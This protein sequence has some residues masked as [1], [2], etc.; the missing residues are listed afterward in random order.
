MARVWGR[1][2]LPRS[3]A[4]SPAIA[5]SPDSWP[6]I[7]AVA[8]L[9]WLGLFALAPGGI[10]PKAVFPTIHDAGA[11]PA[12]QGARHFLLGLLLALLACR[13][14][15]VLQ[16][17]LA[18]GVRSILAFVA[19]AAPLLLITIGASHL[20]SAGLVPAPAWM[21]PGLLVG[22]LL[23]ALPWL[24]RG[25]RPGHARWAGPA[26]LLLLGAA[27]L[28][29]L[30]PL[31]GAVGGDGFIAGVAQRGYLFVRVAMPWIVLGLILGAAGQSLRARFWTMG[32]VAMFVATAWV[33]ELP[34]RWADVAELAFIPAALAFGLWLAGSL[35]IAS[36]AF[37]RAPAPVADAG[38]GELDRDDGP[39]RPAPMP[40][41][42]R[43]E[44]VPRRSAGRLTSTREYPAAGLPSRVLARAA[45]V[46]IALLVAVSLL[47]FPRWALPLALVYGLFAAL[48]WR[49]PRAALLVIPAALP[50]FDLAP[51]T[52]RF[53]FDE[54][55]RLLL[56]ALAMTLWR[57]PPA[58]RLSWSPWLVLPLAA[59]ALVSLLVGLLP[60]QPL[61][62]HAFADY[63]SSVNALRVAKG[64][65]WGGL[66]WWL[67]R[68]HGG[69]ESAHRLLAAGLAI[70]VA[71]VAMAALWEAWLFGG[72][73]GDG[74]YRV[75]ATF[76][77]MHTGGGHIEAF[78][79][80]AM[81]YLAW[82][83]F[84]Q[85]RLAIKAV[86]AGV[87]LLA[88][89]ALVATVARGG[90]IGLAVALLILCAGG[91][92]VWLRGGRL[93]AGVAIAAAVL[94][95]GVGLVAAWGVQ[96]EY[97]Q[98][99]FERLEEDRDIRLRH[100]RDAL[101]MRDEGWVT[102]AF[103]MGLGSFPRVWLVNH[104]AEQPGGYRYA[105]EGDNTYLGLNSGGTLYMAQM[106]PVRPG[107]SYRL[108]LDTRSDGVGE[109]LEI[110]ICEKLLFNSHRCQWLNVGFSAA[111]PA[112]R[113]HEL[114][115]ESGEIGGG[116][117]WQRRPVQLSL[118]NPEAGSMVQVDNLSLR[119]D[120]GRELVRNGDFV[121]GG[122]H[123][124][125][126]SGDHLPWHIKNLWVHTLF[127][128]G[129]LGLLTLNLTL[130]AG[131]L[132][133]A[134]KAWRG[135]GRAVAALAAL[136]GLLTVGVVDSLLDAPR[137]A[138][139]LVFA[140]LAAL[141]AEPARRATRP[142]GRARAAQHDQRQQGEVGPQRGDRLGQSDNVEHA[143]GG[144]QL[145]IREP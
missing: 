102:Q 89:A 34:L 79:V 49:H 139:L 119:D 41:E 141:P 39:P 91:A 54:F 59:A 108:S 61:D 53:H 24:A 122:D 15:A 128:H 72:V 57:L 92:R 68:R 40:A 87:L 78:L 118:Y 7:L 11:V 70:G 83:L 129:W 9:L 86:V 25:T 52:G 23:G 21:M 101:S 112:W 65:L 35:P 12:W 124:F 63:W 14:V 98:Q 127:E 64:L 107:Q 17:G 30:L 121:R 140:L 47:D 131:L 36:A 110:S 51:W 135:D 75:T 37:A 6:A 69:G 85:G 10:A 130:L 113:G 18:A 56:V 116:P 100:W 74:E 142:R 5:P 16:P 19:T 97:F 50:L 106:L 31:P 137:L 43:D 80:F 1:F 44:R 28:L 105:R 8:T 81:P 48:L 104:L 71:G 26:W 55:D 67:W 84:A 33:L 133:L 145:E 94:A 115:F 132:T 3:A 42:P 88:S 22:A 73:A 109:R 46:A 90:I 13:A 134:R 136:G 96:G 125:F 27:P 4:S 2:A 38:V 77:S 144:P 114:R 82:S 126:K 58:P 66:F 95:A 29:V 138:L 123:W 99:R 117:W 103:G 62:E 120:A 143:G 20:A 111:D 32:C 76:S 60:W 45:A 93:R